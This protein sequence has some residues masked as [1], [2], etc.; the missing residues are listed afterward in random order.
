ME[1]H[2]HTGFVSLAVTTVGVIIGIHIIRWT[3]AKLAANSTTETLG[4]ALGA[5]VTF[6]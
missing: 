3:A 4:K 5:T 2:L 6:A 1:G